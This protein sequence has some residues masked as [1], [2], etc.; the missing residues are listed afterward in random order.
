METEYFGLN[1]S[2]YNSEYDSG[3]NVIIDIENWSDVDKVVHVKPFMI[4]EDACL[5][6]PD[7]YSFNLQVLAGSKDQAI[8]STGDGGDIPTPGT[9]YFKVEVEGEGEFFFEQEIEIGL[10]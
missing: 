7:V 10:K 9:Y 3:Q 6:D 2:T 1:V 5:V 8:F 4:T